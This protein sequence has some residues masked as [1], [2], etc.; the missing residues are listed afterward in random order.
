MKIKVILPVTSKAIL[1]KTREE[2]K[3]WSSHKFQIDV[4]GNSIGTPSIESRYDE[5]MCMPDLIRIA[6]KAESEQYDGILISC[7]FDT[8]LEACR[9]KLSIPVVAPG[10]TSI[11]FAAELASSFA[12]LTPLSSCVNIIG[13][14]VNQLNLTPKL[15][16][17][18]PLDIPVDELE[19]EP[20][21]LNVLTENAVDAIE[22]SGAHSIILGCTGIIGLAEKLR[23]NLLQ[24]GHNVPIIDPVATS[25]EYLKSLISLH[26]S[27]SKT[28][29]VSPSKKDNNLLSGKS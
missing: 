14:I 7:M 5:I 10:R 15:A 12:I 27:Q 6:E 1:E 20:V 24:A 4:E 25:I 2:M 9:E 17:L 18:K 3:K 16:A 13:S 26:L 8:G 29:Y 11:L 28:S 21:L 22:N 23:N 19:N